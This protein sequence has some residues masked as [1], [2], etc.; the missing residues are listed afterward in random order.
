[1][2]PRGEQTV[3]IPTDDGAMPAYLF[4]PQSGSGPGIVLLQEIFGVS[5]YIRARAADLVRLGYVVVAPEIYWRLDERTIDESAPD[6]LDRAM[7]VVSRLDWP[8]AV[9]DAAA[10]VRAVRARPETGGVVGLVGFCFGGGLAFN[11]AAVER[12]DALVSY[13]GSALPNLLDLAPQVD[14][15]SLHHFGLADTFIPADE[16]ERIRAALAE[17]DRV[18]F[19][20]YPGAGHAFDNPHPMFHHALAAEQAW[21]ATTDFLART[22]PTG[23]PR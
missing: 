18:E 8:R 7:G 6:F 22:L 4:S 20:T 14:V 13:Y 10:T 15:P 11:T 16:V 9:Q 19:R 5:D 21:A 2:T 23:K 3:Q 17:S 1:M 12:V